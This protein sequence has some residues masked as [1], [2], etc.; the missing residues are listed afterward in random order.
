MRFGFVTV[1]ASYGEIYGPSVSLGRSLFIRSILMKKYLVVIFSLI[2]ATLMFISAP[3]ALAQTVDNLPLAVTVIGGNVVEGYI[4]ST[5][6]KVELTAVA[7]PVAGFNL[8]EQSIKLKLNGIELPVHA[9]VNGNTVSYSLTGPSNFFSNGINNLVI[10]VNFSPTISDSEISQKSVTQNFS[11][12]L[13]GDFTAPKVN[14]DSPLNG[15]V[16]K[17]EVALKYS[18][19]EEASNVLNNSSAAQVLIDG[20]MTALKNGDKISVSPGKHFLQLRV[21]D[22]AG[23]MT[24]VSS[25]FTYDNYI[26]FN[27]ATYFDHSIVYS[28]DKIFIKGWTEA[29]SKVSIR[30]TD[31]DP[32]II[33]NQDGYFEAT[34]DASEIGIG[35]YGV[36]VDIMDPAGNFYSWNIGEVTIKKAKV[37]QN[38]KVQRDY[39]L[40]NYATQ[41]QNTT[42]ATAEEDEIAQKPIQLKSTSDEKAFSTNWSAWIILLFAIVL[43]SGIS[44]VGY[45]GYE[46]FFGGSNAVVNEHDTQSSKTVIKKNKMASKETEEPKEKSDDHSL[47]W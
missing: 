13:T 24:T 21:T 45:Y 30:F 35:N 7:Q 47:R 31:Y 41:A 38:T 29:G 8:E 9:T 1:W 15:S 23:N 33:A 39:P 5:N 34:I 28:G 40:A 22:P 25:E 20:E 32:E 44:T 43:A 17:D 14:L 42:E 27:D 37:V 46:W 16:Y 36:F 4:N 18:I 3:K 2:T 11:A 6:L 26:Y 19:A 12:S 10:E